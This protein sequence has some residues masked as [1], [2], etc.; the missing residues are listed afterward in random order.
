AQLVEKC[1]FGS[2]GQ[3][4]HHLKPLLAADLVRE[5]SEHVSRKGF[6]EVSPHRVQGVVMILCGIADLTNGQYVRP[7]YSGSE[8][9]NGEAEG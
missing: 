9:G 1:G 7:R 5:C 6:Y 8:D 4:Y 2:T 3:A